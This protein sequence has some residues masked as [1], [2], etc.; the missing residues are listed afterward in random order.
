MTF[1]WAGLC[2]Y[3]FGLEE[4]KEIEQTFYCL[5]GGA[6]LNIITMPVMLPLALGFIELVKKIFSL[7]HK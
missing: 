2:I 6:V 4:G 7:F 1:V 3:L 5:L